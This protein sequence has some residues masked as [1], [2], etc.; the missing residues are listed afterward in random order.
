MSSHH[1]QLYARCSEIAQTMCKIDDASDLDANVEVAPASVGLGVFAKKA[2]KR[3]HML[4][5]EKALFVMDSTVS[6]SMESLMAMLACDETDPFRLHAAKFDGLD[7]A[8]REAIAAFEGAD[9][10]ERVQRNAL[11]CAGDK[12]ALFQTTSRINHGCAPNALWTQPVHVAPG[13]EKDAGVWVGVVATRDIAPGDEIVA[14]YGGLDALAMRRAPRRAAIAEKF[15]FN[16]MCSE[17][18]CPYGQI[19]DTRTRLASGEFR[20][21]ARIGLVPPLEV[22]PMFDRI[23]VAAVNAKCNARAA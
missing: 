12:M 18:A 9:T 5:V 17:C 22:L 4:Y 21:A 14:F 13:A 2:F 1:S 11:P 8:T 3:G 16:C 6:P 23:M 20:V 7:D 10:S 15:R 19:E